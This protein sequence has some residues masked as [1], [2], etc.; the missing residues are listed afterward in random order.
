MLELQDN[1][2]N[3]IVSEFYQFKVKVDLL[4]IFQLKVICFRFLFGNDKST[5]SIGW[6]L[7]N[8]GSEYALAANGPRAWYPSNFA[9]ACW[10]AW[11]QARWI[12]ILVI[13]IFGC[14]FR[15]CLISVKY[16]SKNKYFSEMLFLE[17][18]NIF[19]CLV[20]LLKLL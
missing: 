6:S 5:N 10:L 12:L 11:L 3:V 2:Q 1:F 4:L 8:D 13:L 20:A 7:E 19:K 17:K 18:E 16:F 9:H 14:E 15:L